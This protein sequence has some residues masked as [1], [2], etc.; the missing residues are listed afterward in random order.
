MYRLIVFIFLLSFLSCTEDEFVIDKNYFGEYECLR[1]TYH[2]D[3]FDSYTTYDTVKIL[4]E[5]S[6][7][8]KKIIVDNIPVDIKEDGSFESE[9]EF[10]DRPDGWGQTTGKFYEDSIYFRWVD[11]FGEDSRT[12]EGKKINP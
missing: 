8:E 12:H 3:F 11:S 9:P 10:R 6:S 1:T 2:F 4:V 7:Y 5:S